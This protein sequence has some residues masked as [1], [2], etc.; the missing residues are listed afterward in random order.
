MTTEN[1]ELTTIKSIDNDLKVIN[2]S[3]QK[4]YTFKKKASWKYTNNLDNKAR[5]CIIKIMTG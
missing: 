3:L 4:D 1:K 5:S 2:W